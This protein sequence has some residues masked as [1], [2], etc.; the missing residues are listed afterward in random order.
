MLVDLR[1]LMLL[2]FI[3]GLPKRFVIPRFI[4]VGAVTV[5]CKG[6]V[7]DISMTLVSYVIG[8]II[9]NSC[10]RIHGYSKNELRK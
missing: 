3:V 1:I 10:R 8:L 5:L 4:L 2:G 7:G 6:Y 9:G